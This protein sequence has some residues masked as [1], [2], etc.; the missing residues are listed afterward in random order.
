VA[1]GALAATAHTQA[2][3]LCGTDSPLVCT[4][5][6]CV[7]DVFLQDRLWPY[8]TAKARPLAC[9]PPLDLG[10]GSSSSSGGDH[11]QDSS[12][13]SSG[14][15]D[16]FGAEGQGGG[17]GS[18]GGGSAGGYPAGKTGNHAASS[19]GHRCHSTDLDVPCT[20]IEALMTLRLHAPLFA[21]VAR[22]AV[23]P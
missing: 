22:P 23:R 14:G 5:Q 13:G 10:G 9:M 4:W 16:G 21:T 1:A 18:G 15:S 12:S 8:S 6:L 19:G 2:S 7:L 17:S 3:N 20:I 11:G